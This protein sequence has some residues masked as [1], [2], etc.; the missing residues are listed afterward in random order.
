MKKSKKYVLLLSL[1]LLNCIPIIVTAEDNK[2]FI[3]KDNNI[4]YVNDNQIQKGIIK[5]DEKYYF[6]GEYT[7]KLQYGWITSSITYKRYYG[8]KE[9]NGALATGFKKI[10]NATYYF[11]EKGEL[12]TG[13]KI[14]DNSAYFLGEYTG[15]VQ[16]G[17]ITS[18][19]NGEK[20]YADE[21]GKIMI[22]FQNIDKDTYY[23]NE[24]GILQKGIQKINKKRYFLGEYSGKVQKGYVQSSLT[25]KEYYTSETGEILSGIFK[26]GNDKYYFSEKGKEYGIVHTE[27]KSY[28][29]GEYTGK[30]QYG[31]ITSSLTNKKYY[32]DKNGELKSGLITIGNKSYYFDEKTKDAQK[33]F[34][35]IDNNISYYGEND[36]TLVTGTK[37]INGET[38]FFTKEG[39][40]YNGFVSLEDGTYYFIKG[41]KQYG[42]TYI[43]GEDYFL[44]EYTGKVQTGFI[45]SLKNNNYYADNTGKILKGIT[46]ID[47]EDYFL[48][49]YSG[50]VQKGLIQSS[51]NKEYYYVDENGKIYKGIFEINGIEYSAYT[52]GILKNGFVN[53]NNNT[54][55]Y[56]KGKLIK[57]VYGLNGDLYFLGE[58][59]G[60]LQYGWIT[61]SLTNDKY[62]ANERG[63]L[64]KGIQKLNNNLYFFGENTARL[65]YGWIHAETGKIY[66]ANAEGIIQTGDQTIFF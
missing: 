8:I 9:E 65:Q 47:G 31:L 56:E 4:Y 41:Y 24:K 1:L 59:T 54:Y 32:A 28:F 12:Q 10:E 64:L 15:K 46:T 48:G 45:T 25:Q 40:L 5:V 35:K 62:Y 52:T 26:V 57:G 39:I 23:F 7:G 50:K 6:L 55:Y 60:K 43:N 27:D 13:I 66:Y 42:I 29:L 18:S 58:Y 19:I 51:K 38:Y 33:G 44:G 53:E 14:I 3:Q 61:S 2:G 34:I 22:G 17:W 36:Y 20:Y 11:D 16:H 21:T 30:L 63:I 49:E 37:K